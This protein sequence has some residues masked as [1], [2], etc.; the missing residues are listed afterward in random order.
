MKSGSLQT[1][2]SLIEV[3]I[4]LIILLLGLLG[5]AGLSMRA[6]QAEFE[7]YQRAQ[8]LVLVEDMAQRIGANQSAAACY[9]SFT[10]VGPA[11][12][13]S[14]IGVGSSVAANVCVPAGAVNASAVAMA[15]SDLLDWDAQ[16][17]GLAVQDGSNAAGA[18]LGARGCITN[19]ASG[20]L[21]QLVWQAKTKTSAPPAGLSCGQGLY[22]DEQYRR[23]LARWVRIIDLTPAY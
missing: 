15:Q 20:V 17:D 14:Y 22:G 16:L 7:S 23:V 10:A 9:Y 2:F 13:T 6:N 21:V 5:V 12:G 11:S 3:L 4:S 19:T 18:M 8:A 1:G